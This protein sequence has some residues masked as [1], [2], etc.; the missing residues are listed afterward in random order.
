MAYN[1]ELLKVLG[2]IT[3]NQEKK[4]INQIFDQYEKVL[5]SLFS[6]PPSHKST[7]NV[8]LHLFGYV[9]DKLGS[10]EKQF[11]LDLIDQYRNEKISLNVLTHVL[12]SWVVR[13][14]EP[15]LSNQT[16]FNPFPED[17]LEEQ[18]TVIADKRR[19]WE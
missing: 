2:Q 1:Q 12:K 5:F 16:F 6:K 8:I 18:L 4:Q 9:S 13:F 11:Y 3:A 10:E 17:L 15:Y 19:Y 14:S 7:I